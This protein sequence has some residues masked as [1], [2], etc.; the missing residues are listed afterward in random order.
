[1]SEDSDYIEARVRKKDQKVTVRKYAVKG[2][3]HVDTY[4]VDGETVLMVFRRAEKTVEAAED[5]R[6]E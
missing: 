2:H 5:E 4:P 3:L 1:M 6:E